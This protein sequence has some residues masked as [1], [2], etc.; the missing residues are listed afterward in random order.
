[1][2][3]LITER[4]R[5]IF[6]D[7]YDFGYLD[8]Y[9]LWKKYWTSSEDELIAKTAVRKRMK[10]LADAGYIKR[11]AHQSMDRLA[12]SGPPPSVYTLGFKGLEYI[13][14]YLGLDVNWDKNRP[15][16]KGDFIDHH[17][18]TAH[19]TLEFTLRHSLKVDYRGEQNAK[20]STYEN[21]KPKDIFKP[22]LLWNV[23]K[24]NLPSVPYFI[25]FERSVRRSQ[26]KMR[27]K[28]TGQYEYSSKGLYENHDI[29]N[30]LNNQMHPCLI[31]ISE[32]DKVNKK[33]REI[34]GGFN[35]YQ[36]NSKTGESYYFNDILFTTVGAFD[37]DSSGS[38]FKRID[39]DNL[40][41]MDSYYANV[42]SFNLNQNFKERQMT[43]Q[44]FPSYVCSRRFDKHVFKAD[45][46]FNLAQS[47]TQNVSFA[48]QMI[49][50]HNMKEVIDNLNR[51]INEGDLTK[52]LCFEQSIYK[53][54]E[55]NPRMIFLVETLDDVEPLSIMIREK[56]WSQQISK[57]FIGVV[58][59]VLY[60]PFMAD[61]FDPFSGKQIE[62]F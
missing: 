56:T 51:V 42:F 28:V 36:N 20:Y 29:L 31:Y 50:Q 15:Y 16:R 38:I 27:E 47:D 23:T 2:G 5:D 49:N 35:W 41:F 4:D 11:L 44:H 14:N 30:S 45:G 62:L 24:K 1:M 18:K 52:H 58:D 43:V 7:I 39:S 21:N 59:Y 22:D 55:N 34:M 54:Q 3:I 10:R 37:Q 60:K 40:S 32:D 46:V 33:Y 53:T 61:Y 8:F 13:S 17:L 25:E 57:F 48:Y 26:K 12:N 19:L 6:L 9:Y